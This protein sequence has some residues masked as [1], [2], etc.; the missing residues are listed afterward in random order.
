MDR[1]LD[2]HEIRHRLAAHPGWQ[3]DVRGLHA[4]FQFDSF[5]AAMAF[6]AA[7]VDGIEQRDHHPTWHNAEKVVELH[8]ATLHKGP[9]VTERD[10]ELVAFFDAMRQRQDSDGRPQSG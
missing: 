6:M 3:G 8:L 4:R 9:R 7:C 2:D 5:R 10:F 1:T